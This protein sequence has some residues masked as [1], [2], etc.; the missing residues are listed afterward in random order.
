MAQQVEEASGIPVLTR[1]SDVIMAIGVIGM[2]VVMVIPIPTIMLDIFLSFNITLAVVVLL[3]AMYTLKPLEFSVFPSLL[4][5]ATLLRLSLN[6]AS[7]R[8]ILL[9]GNE[10][11]AAAGQDIR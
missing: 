7:T 4:L 9:H 5:L 3:V 2:L 11:T 6:V 1:N 8:L 10:G